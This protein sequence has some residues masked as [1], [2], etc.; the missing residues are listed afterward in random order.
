MS[1]RLLRY[2]SGKPYAV[3]VTVPSAGLEHG[4]RFGVLGDEL[5]R[6]H[7]FGWTGQTD[8]RPPTPE[9]SQEALRRVGTRVERERVSHSAE[10]RQ[11]ALELVASGLSWAAAGREL[12]VGK[13]TVQG[14][15]KAAVAGNGDEA[16]AH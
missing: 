1:S 6:P 5:L 15:V 11:R 9:E 8:A 14:W 10:T 4:H 16:V 3:E 12:G 13:S 2:P 7:G